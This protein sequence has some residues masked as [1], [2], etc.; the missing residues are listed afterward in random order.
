MNLSQSILSTTA[1]L[2]I[3]AAGAAQAG[4]LNDRI[5]AGEPIRI[6]FANE[7][8][9]A[10]P[11]PDGAPMGFVNAYTLALLERMGHDNIEVVVTDWGGLI[12]ALN[13][14]RIDIVTGG[15]NITAPRCESIAFSEPMLAAGDA[16]V[17]PAGN[18]AGITTYDD[19]VDSD[20]I[21]VTGAGYSNLEAARRVGVPDGRI[22]TVPGPSEIVAALRAGR[23]QAGGVAYFT[24]VEMAATQ[25]GIELAD[26]SAMPDWSMNWAAIGFHKNDQDFVDAFNAAQE[27]WLG[28]PEML[29]IVGEYGFSADN[30]PDEAVTTEWVCANR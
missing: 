15:L 14:G 9:F 4:P 27:D 3:C 16:F 28:S 8:P 7:V 18:A 11:G 6:G 20:A 12:P 13:A 29:E 26:P 10:Y 1:V 19:L 24:G 23:A 5:A 17:V 30:V 25:E 21:F 22:M 2:A